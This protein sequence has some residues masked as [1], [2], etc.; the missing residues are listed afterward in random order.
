MNNV[1][2]ITIT[3]LA[4]L[5]AATSASAKDNGFSTNFS[6]SNQSGDYSKM[7]PAAGKAQEEDK[8]TTAKKSDEVKAKAEKKEPKDKE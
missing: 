4:T 2:K 3:L 1:S 7:A 6:G 5:L 8:D